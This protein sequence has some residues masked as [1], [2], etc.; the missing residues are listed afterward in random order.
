MINA[1]RLS[2]TFTYILFATVLA[3]SFSCQK[4]QNDRNGPAASSDQDAIGGPGEPAPGLP[5]GDPR[6]EVVDDLNNDFTDNCRSA[7]ADSPLGKTFAAM[8][9][10]VGG[11]NCTETY[12][13]LSQLSTLDLR[14]QG[15]TDL[16]P[17][18]SFKGE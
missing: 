12:N 1:K 10:S 18:A 3:T 13:S 4:E 14:G 17:I 6:E 15:L 2:I 8:T 11:R 16:S 7:S 9:K 5:Q